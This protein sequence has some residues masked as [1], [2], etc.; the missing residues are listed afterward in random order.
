MLFIYY[1]VAQTFPH[2]TCYIKLQ[3]NSGIYLGFCS[4][5]FKFPNNS[6]LH[7]GI[8]SSPMSSIVFGSSNAK[9]S[10]IMITFLIDS[11]VSLQTALFGDRFVTR[12]VYTKHSFYYTLGG[13]KYCNFLASMCKQRHTFTFI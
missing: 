13:N 4:S 11:M 8:S 1:D 7:I 10:T 12:I 9:G 6:P 5:I 3:Q 2:Y